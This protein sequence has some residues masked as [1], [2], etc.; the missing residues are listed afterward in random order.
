M[1][2]TTP[3]QVLVLGAV[4]PTL[5]LSEQLREHGIWIS[6]IRPPTVPA[7]SARLRITFSAAHSEAHLDRLLDT[8]GKLQR[9]G[10]FGES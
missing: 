1:P 8:L 6:A 5:R 9:T 2:S 10:L 7:G 3:I 4:E